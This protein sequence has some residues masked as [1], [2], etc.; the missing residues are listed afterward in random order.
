MS[1]DESS[2]LVSDGSL[3][4]DAGRG[5]PE[6]VVAAESDP[7]EAEW[8]Q[9]RPKAEELV[10]ESKQDPAGSTDARRDGLP[11]DRGDEADELEPIVSRRR[12]VVCPESGGP[13]RDEHGK[14]RR[15]TDC[16]Q[17]E[18]E[19]VEAEADAAGWEAIEEADRRAI[20]QANQRR[21]ETFRSSR[22]GLVRRSPL[23]PRLRARR[24]SPGS[25]SP[26]PKATPARRDGSSRDGPS[27]LGDGEPEHGPPP[28]GFPLNF[29]DRAPVLWRGR[30]LR[31]RFCEWRER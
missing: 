3:D 9:T 30:A 6:E 24:K 26:R 14:V 4:L 10:R 27:D 12:V 2:P 20:E 7:V 5:E 18:R 25:R 8:A 31:C 28:G 29:V 22:P 15:W 1:S 21:E 11:P 19:T 16:T 23:G 13:V 17:A